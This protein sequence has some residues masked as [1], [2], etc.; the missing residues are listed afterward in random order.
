MRPR[1]KYHEPGLAEETYRDIPDTTPTQQ[2]A[3]LAT[4]TRHDA[5]DLAHYLGLTPETP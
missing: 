4:L 3:A 5:L 2:A 1:S